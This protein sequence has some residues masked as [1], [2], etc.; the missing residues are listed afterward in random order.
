M[1]DDCDLIVTTTAKYMT[2]NIK[3]YC[4]I[5]PS[6]NWTPT[7]EELMKDETMP[8]LSVVLFLKKLLKHSKQAVSAKKKKMRLIETYASDI[9]SWSLG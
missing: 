1:E 3:N 8:P 2:S 6:L 4:N 9:Y 5:L 7:I